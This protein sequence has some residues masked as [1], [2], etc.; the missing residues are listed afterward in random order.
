MRAAL[1]GRRGEGLANIVIHSFQLTNQ[2]RNEYSS[3]VR[4]RIFLKKNIFYVKLN[5]IVAH[6]FVRAW[7]FMAQQVNLF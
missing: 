3:D 2:I 6:A 7:K 4:Y 5:Q 1:R